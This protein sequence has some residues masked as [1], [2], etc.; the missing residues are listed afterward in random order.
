MTMSA[1]TLIIPYPA[2]MAHVVNTLHGVEWT[3]ASLEAGMVRGP[4]KQNR[5]LCCV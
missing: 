3:L 2:E 1:H 4:S 5:V